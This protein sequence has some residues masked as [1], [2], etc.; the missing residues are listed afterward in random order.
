MTTERERLIEHVR[1]CDWLMEALRAVRSIGLPSWCIG[2]GAVR[3]CV[4]DA[5]HRHDAPS[6]LA[7]VDVAFFD[8][9]D[10]RAE[11][12]AEIEHRLRALLPDVPWEVTNQAAVHTWFAA[13]FGDAVAPLRSL[14]EAIGSWPE[15]ATCVG[16]WLDEEDGLHVIAPLGL[17]DLLGMIVRRNPARVSVSTYRERVAAKRYEERWP[18]VRV[19]V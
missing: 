9:G 19:E 15:Y 11:R 17:E 16:V 1:A 18:R 2:A 12:D 13:Y 14:G 3:N 6:S 4:W 5:L 7:D 10:L 8:A